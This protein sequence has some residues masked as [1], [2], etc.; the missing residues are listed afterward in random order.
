MRK[1]IRWIAGFLLLLLL[2]TG[3]QKKTAQK[4]DNET[5]EKKPLT[6]ADIYRKAQ[7]AILGKNLNHYVRTRK[8]KLKATF[9]T[10]PTLHF[11]NREEV[12]YANDPYTL[13]DIRNT[14]L[15]FGDDEV[16]TSMEVYLQRERDQTVSYIGYNGE[17]W[18][19]EPMEE[20]ISEVYYES[21]RYNMLPNID[22]SLLTLEKETREMDGKEVYVLSYTI[23][24]REE[25]PY[26]TGKEMEECLDKLEVN[27]TL[28][29]ERET[30][31]IVRREATLTN[32]TGVFSEWLYSTLETDDEEIFH[33]DDWDFREY[34]LTFKELDYGK[35]DVPKVPEVG[36]Q[37]ALQNAG[38]GQV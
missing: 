1:N 4:P 10:A 31:G 29:V 21:Y 12:W 18:I 37:K 25:Y 22:A 35:V 32:I 8:V 24:G 38:L 30:Y 26:L 5:P 13:C 19:R 16:K 15:N 3:C 36:R 27:I 28:Y 20:M 33:E 6:A 23:P 17:Y 2:F 11:E 9:V 34:V 14:T 7:Y